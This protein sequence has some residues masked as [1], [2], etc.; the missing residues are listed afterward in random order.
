[1]FRN[2]GI[3]LFQLWG[4]TVFLSP[5]WFIVAIYAF[6]QRI[7]D[8]QF[9]GWAAAEVLSLF[10]LVLMHEFGHALACRSVGGQ[11]DRIILWPLG[12]VAFVNPPRRPGA[13]LWSIVAGPLVN[14]VILA[15]TFPLFNISIPGNPDLQTFLHT[16]VFINLVLLIFNILPVY[17]LDGG[18]ILWSLLWFIMGYSTSLMVAAGLGLII[19]IA[20]GL[21]ALSVQDWWLSLMAAFAIY[22]SVIGIQYAVAVR[23]RDNAP[24][25]PGVACP[26]CHKPPPMG[27]FWRCGQ[28][29]TNFDAFD[30]PTACPTCGR[31]H[32][33]TACLECGAKS[34]FVEWD[35]P[36]PMTIN[37]HQL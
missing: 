29:G 11:A 2:N 18:K 23:R 3:R 12:G 8:Y 37:A 34:Q 36:A 7:H 6:Q 16:M 32:A 1:M 14:V 30:Y 33:V 19:A 15:L 4:I 17:P 31:P 13:W 20:G 35:L 10:A 27:P 9:P 24:R 26:S 25:R 22:Q 28:C 5:S 21:W